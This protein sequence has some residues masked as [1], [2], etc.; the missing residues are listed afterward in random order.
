MVASAA[1]GLPGPWSATDVGAVAIP[2]SATFGGERFCWRLPATRTPL[3]SCTF[4]GTGSTPIPPPQQ[5]AITSKASFPISDLGALPESATPIQAP[6]SKAP[7]TGIA[8]GRRTGC[9]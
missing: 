3:A 4:S 8:C 7:A 6:T 1:A 2:G 9:G 5:E